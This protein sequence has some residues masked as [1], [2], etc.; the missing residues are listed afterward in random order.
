[1]ASSATLRQLAQDRRTYWA[2]AVGGVLLLSI[3]WP[4]F[5]ASK[6]YDRF[7]LGNYFLYSNWVEPGHGRLYF[8][9][10][11]DY[12]L[13][14]NLLFAPFH[15]VARH[16]PLFDS[17]LVTFGWLWVTSAWVLFVV[18]ARILAERDVSRLW[19]WL[20][21]ACVYFTLFRY[22]I[23]LVLLS[24]AFLYTLERGKYLAASLWF[25]LAI[26][27]KGYGLFLLPVY[28]IYLINQIGFVRA[29]G[30]TAVATGPF[31]LE[32]LAV[33]VYGGMEALKAPYVFQANRPTSDESMYRALTLLVGADAWAVPPRLAQIFQVAA[34]LGAAALRPRTFDEWLRAATFATLGFIFFSPVTSPQFFMW[35]IPMVYLVQAP[36]LAKGLNILGWVSLINYPI[37]QYIWGSKLVAARFPAI[38]SFFLHVMFPGVII[39]LNAIRAW[40]LGWLLFDARRN[41]NTA[42]STEK[43]LS[44]RTG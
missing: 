38:Q 40:I 5:Y 42:V 29:A 30:F 24:L 33:F 31:V 11:S 35:L 39:V 15:W 22:E 14:A 36:L 25:G 17:G 6:I 20:S 1:M 10:Y 2:A 3:F 37:I 4:Q 44:A 41:A 8:E 34:A 27:L 7:D 19:L 16:L 18:T 13:L 26:A 12:L 23:Y 43:P 32:H 28:G 21:P 9:V